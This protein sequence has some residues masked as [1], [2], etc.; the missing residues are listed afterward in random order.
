MK[1]GLGQ[2]IWTLKAEQITNLVEFYF[3]GE[4]FYVLTLGIS[5]ISI[6]LFYL[7]VFPDK[8]FRQFT[9]AVMAACLGYTIAFFFATLLQCQP[10]SYTWNKWDGLH[11]GTCTNVHAQSWTAAATSIAL[12]IIV[13]IL[14][15]RQLARLQMGLAKKIM[16]M[17]MFSVG[18]FVVVVSIIRLETL[19]HFANS[20][21]LTWDYTEAGTWS[22]IEVYTS[23]IC[24]CMPALRKLIVKM[25]PSI[26]ST[27][28]GSKASGATGLSG[29]QSSSG[30]DALQSG[31]STRITVNPRTGD[32]GDFVPLVDIDHT[33]AKTTVSGNVE[34]GEK[35]S[36]WIMRTSSVEIMNHAK[37]S[38]AGVSSA[39]SS[40]SLETEIPAR[41]REHI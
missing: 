34:P 26:R 35:S 8:R 31:K 5:K 3:F 24:G 28:G 9:Y 6:C 41:N 37:K 36:S 29:F 30:K 7:R 16:V 23:I 11:K 40:H 20:Q 27:R 32:E 12:D 14:P 10:I 38:N 21:N 4:I 2:D 19:I 33:H 17:S 39:N 22:L 25:W 13:L 15:L 18:T 1:N